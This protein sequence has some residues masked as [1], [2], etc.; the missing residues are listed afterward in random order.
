VIKIK[1]GSIIHLYKY[2]LALEEAIK[3]DFSSHIESEAFM[4]HVK[5]VLEEF[6]RLYKVLINSSKDIESVFKSPLES[7]DYIDGNGPI[8]FEDVHKEELCNLFNESRSLQV[9]IFN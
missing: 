1:F 5:L 3:K 6:R 4:F 7:I 9:K 2:E 8:I